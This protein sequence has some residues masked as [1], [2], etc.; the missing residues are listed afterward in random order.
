[1]ISLERVKAE[2]RID[3]NHDDPRLLDLID[4]AIFVLQQFKARTM[5]GTVTDPSTQ[6]LMT[7]LD[8]RFVYV[9]VTGRFNSSQRGAL[10]N[11]PTTSEPLYHIRSSQCKSQRTFNSAG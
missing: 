4:E 7:P 1:M 8:K 2:L 5:V 3:G 11:Q 9:Y 10:Q 6:V